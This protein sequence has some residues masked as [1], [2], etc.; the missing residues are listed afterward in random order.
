MDSIVANSEGVKRSARTVWT[1]D[2]GGF[3]VGRSVL[4]RNLLKSEG[5]I[6]GE[7]STAQKPQRLHFESIHIPDST[8]RLPCLQ[9]QRCNLKQGRRV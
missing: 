4:I 1:I 8:G 7:D 9:R 2:A 6:Q 3:V 5:V